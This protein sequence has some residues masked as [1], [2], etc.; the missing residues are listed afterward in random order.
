[1]ATITHDLTLNTDLDTAYRAV[2]TPAGLRGWWCRD[3]D[4]A[5]AA[6]GHHQL[7]FQKEGQL[8]KM[9][10]DV[11]TLDPSGTIAWTC[12]ANGNPVWPGTTLTWSLTRSEGGVALHFEHAGFPEDQSP[13]YKMTAQVWHH[14]M[15]SLK[16]Y[17]E[18]GQGMP[19]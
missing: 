7:R 4:L 6:G 17:T 11:D 19:A 9:D 16:A 1:M 15:A 3:A 12:T 18:S 10:F 8:V 13:P 5:D 2:A 14:F